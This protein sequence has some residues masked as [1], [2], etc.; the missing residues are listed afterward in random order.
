M[1]YFCKETDIVIQPFCVDQNNWLKQNSMAW[2]LA[3][4]RFNGI[5]DNHYPQERLI[6]FLNVHK[7]IFPNMA[8]LIFT[9]GSSKG[10]AGYLVNNQQ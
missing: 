4:I 2:L 9:Y 7:V 5:I 10:R 3:Q 8:L 6:K 1:T